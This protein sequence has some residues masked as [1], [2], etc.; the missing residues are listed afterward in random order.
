MFPYIR[1]TSNFHDPWITAGCYFGTRVMSLRVI[2]QNLTH[3]GTK[4]AIA[5]SSNRC[6]FILLKQ[7]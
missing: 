1:N 3:L 7:M 2:L 6:D 4:P 5:S